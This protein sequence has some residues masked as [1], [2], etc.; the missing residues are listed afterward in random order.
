M[1]RGSLRTCRTA[2]AP[3]GFRGRRN[4]R[5]LRHAASP[6][7]EAQR[8]VAGAFPLTVPAAEGRASRAVLTPFH[9]AG[10]ADLSAV[11]AFCDFWDKRGPTP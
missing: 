4:G 2:G 8:N 10:P 3:A 1:R 5:I 7:R 6:Y 9:A 11:A